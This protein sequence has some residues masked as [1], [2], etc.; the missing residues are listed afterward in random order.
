MKK[1]ALV[2]TGFEQPTP[3]IM[4]AWGAWFA[5]IADQTIEHVGPFGP[6]REVTKSGTTEL[7]MGLDAAT[8]YT[9][10]H[11]ND[12]D[13]AVKMAQGCPMITSVRVYELMSMEGH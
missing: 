7:A 6:G 10:I 13:A 2:H 3:Q 4:E 11:A 12:M 8:G 9:L 5:S 1:F